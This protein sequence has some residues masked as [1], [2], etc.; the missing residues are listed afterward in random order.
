MNCVESLLIGIFGGLIVAGILDA[1]SA[2][3]LL[4]VISVI[5]FLTRMIGRYEK[6]SRA[7]STNEKWP[8]DFYALS[9][10]YLIFF[11]VFVIVLA[12]DMSNAFFNNDINLGWYFLLFIPTFA[13]SY[14]MGLLTSIITT[15]AVER[16]QRWEDNIENGKQ[17]DSEN[18]AQ[19]GADAKR[20]NETEA[21]SSDNKVS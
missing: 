5:P 6:F 8:L 15:V 10:T 16:L 19:H 1:F 11:A 18:T 12:G 2:R 7:A 13:V 3:R 4:K 20:K 21:K 9:F 14:L 17:T